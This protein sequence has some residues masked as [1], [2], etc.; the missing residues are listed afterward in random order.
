M[1]GSIVW[2]AS[3]SALTSSFAAATRLRAAAATAEVR[4]ASSTTCASVVAISRIAAA[5][6][7]TCSGMRS[8]DWTD[9]SARASA[10]DEIET[11]FFD[12]D[13]HPPGVALQTLHDLGNAGL[14]G[15]ALLPKAFL[16]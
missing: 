4:S 12:A 11:R 15:H 6:T 8:V 10:C 7:S 1:T 14:E 3:V 9:S 16:P 13:R 2:A 5:T